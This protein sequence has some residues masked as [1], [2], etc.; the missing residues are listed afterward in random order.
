MKLKFKLIVENDPVVEEH[1][2][3]TLEALQ[4]KVTELTPPAPEP[5]GEGA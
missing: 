1:E 2:F 5:E 3:E 4:A